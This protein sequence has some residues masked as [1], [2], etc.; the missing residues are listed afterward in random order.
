M[1]KKERILEF[2]NFICTFGEEMVLLDFAEEIIVP[3]FTDLDLVRSY[4]G[5]DYSFLDVNIFELTEGESSSL[6]IAGRFVKD[7]NLQREQILNRESGRIIK[8]SRSMQSSPTGIFVLILENHKLLYLHETSYAPPLSSFAAT[9]KDFIKRKHEEFIVSIYDERN[10]EA[11]ESRVTFPQLLR[12]FP[13]PQVDIIP[14]ASQGSAE[15]FIN[16]FSIVQR[17]EIVL[18]KAN[19]ELDFSEFLQKARESGESIDANQTRLEYRN[20]REGLSKQEVI[21]RISGS[22]NNQKVKVK[23]KDRSGAILTGNQNQFK[24]RA[25]IK[26]SDLSSTIIGIAKQSLDRFT[27]ALSEGTLQIGETDE[28][29]KEKVR[30]LKN[31]LGSGNE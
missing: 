12:E 14:L 31:K 3:A 19:N 27:E 24:A 9:V 23:G 11:R 30:D 4:K 10:H 15:E 6:A 22:S 17:I 26:I 20:P 1:P 13:I 25:Y 21:R 7:T 5:V 28:V 16:R 8:D 29:S 2:A 18:V